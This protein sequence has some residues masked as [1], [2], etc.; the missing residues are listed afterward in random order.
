MCITSKQYY[1]YNCLT[2][3]KKCSFYS[4]ILLNRKKLCKQLFAFVKL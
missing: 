1:V 2:K 3:P 4:Y